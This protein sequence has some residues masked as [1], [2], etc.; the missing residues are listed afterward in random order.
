LECLLRFTFHIFTGIIPEAL[1]SDCSRCTEIQ[2]I[3]TG[4][5]LLYLIQ[6]RPEWWKELMEKYDSDGSIREKYEYET[7]R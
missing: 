5:V 6:Y 3:Q 1:K 7:E 4:K 2:K